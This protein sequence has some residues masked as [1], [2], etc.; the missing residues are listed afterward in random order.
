M[1][2]A[3]L[4]LAQGRLREARRVVLKGAALLE[5]GVGRYTATRSDRAQQ[6]RDKKLRRRAREKR[7]ERA[8]IVASGGIDIEVRAREHGV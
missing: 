4:R 5:A 7:R 2:M 8:S 3:E 1:E 6:R